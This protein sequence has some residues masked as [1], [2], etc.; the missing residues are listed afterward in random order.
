MIGF[1]SRPGHAAVAISQVPD[2]GRTYH[3]V[4]RRPRKARLRFVKVTAGEE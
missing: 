3:D 2:T 1:V 4:L